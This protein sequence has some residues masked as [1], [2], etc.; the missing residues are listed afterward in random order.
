MTQISFQII[1]NVLEKSL[2][3][4]INI[5]STSLNILFFKTALGIDMESLGFNV[6]LVEAES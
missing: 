4:S 1:T 5:Y 3:Y 6:F 2:T